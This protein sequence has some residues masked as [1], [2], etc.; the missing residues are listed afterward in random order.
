MLGA[1]ASTKIPKSFV[2]AIP[3]T[4]E[5]PILFIAFIALSYRVPLCL[6]KFIP[7][8][9]QNS[10][11]KPSDVIKLTTK[12]AFISI[13]YPPITILSIHIQPINSKNTKNTHRPSIKAKNRLESTWADTI[14]TPK[15]MM[16]FWNKTPFI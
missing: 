2:L 5:L 11:P 8:W 12:T 10:T 3:T 15:A 7:I 16:T 9:L 1:K 4:T 6:R 13:G 14:I